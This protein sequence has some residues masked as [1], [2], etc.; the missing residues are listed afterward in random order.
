MKWNFLFPQTQRERALSSRGKTLSLT[1]FV[2]TSL[3]ILGAATPETSCQ[4]SLSQEILKQCPSGVVQVSPEGVLKC[5]SP[6]PSPSP[7][8]EPTPL[9]SPTTTPTPTPPPPS[10]SPSP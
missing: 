5:L 6:L 3:L 7:C 4:K 10:P 1:W 2:L 8:E 9:P